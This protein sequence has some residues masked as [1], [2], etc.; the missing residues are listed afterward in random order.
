MSGLKFY[1]CNRK[2]RKVIL[3]FITQKSR[4]KERHFVLLLK[5]DHGFQITD[6]MDNTDCGLRI[7]DQGWHGF[8]GFGEGKAFNRFRIF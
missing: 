5:L 4:S 8:H 6:G 3:N 1:E 2:G 7:A